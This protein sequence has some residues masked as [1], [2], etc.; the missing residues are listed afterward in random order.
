[1]SQEAPNEIIVTVGTGIVRFAIGETGMRIECEDENA[2][3][4][5]DC[6]TLDRSSAARL[7]RVLAEALCLRLEARP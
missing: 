7:L 3:G 1:M 6:G 4:W 5:I 2:Q